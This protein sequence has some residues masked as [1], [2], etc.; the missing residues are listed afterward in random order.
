MV[1]RGTC[2]LLDTIIVGSDEHRLPEKKQV[3]VKDLEI[4]SQEQAGLSEPSLLFQ[5]LYSQ[6]EVCLFHRPKLVVL[7]LF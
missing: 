4:F 6:K 5:P 2:S 7:L 1:T 3:L